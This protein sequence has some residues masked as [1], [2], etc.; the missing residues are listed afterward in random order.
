MIELTF[1]LASM[2]R[3]E[4]T[5]CLSIGEAMHAYDTKKHFALVA[6]NFNG[7]TVGTIDID[8]LHAE[9]SRKKA[10]SKHG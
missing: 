1:V 10:M 4:D 5:E 6:I 8:R 9:Y 2:I 3:E 7:V